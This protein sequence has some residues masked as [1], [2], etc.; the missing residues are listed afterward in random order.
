MEISEFLVAFLNQ[1]SDT[2]RTSGLAECAKSVS[3][4]V[5]P[6]RVPLWQGCQIHFLEGLGRP[7]QPG[8][9]SSFLICDLNWSFMSKGGLKTRRHS[10][11]RGMS[12]THV[13]YGDKPKNPVWFYLAPFFSKSVAV[14]SILCLHLLCGPIHKHSTFTRDWGPFD[15]VFCVFCFCRTLLNLPFI[16]WVFNVS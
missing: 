14:W 12:L 3:K 4:T 9:R 6:K 2:A 5:A 16:V 15:C 7:R 8:E 10:A 13:P 1:D 11:L